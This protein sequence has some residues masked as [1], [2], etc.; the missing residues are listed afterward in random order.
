MLGKRLLRPIR[1][2]ATNFL[3]HCQ[4]DF[5]AN[6]SAESEVVSQE[7][8]QRPPG[9]PA[10]AQLARP[11]SKRARKGERGPLRATGETC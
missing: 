10:V 9:L 4:K 3:G 8:R 1:C 6:H 7:A 5:T 2:P 11:N